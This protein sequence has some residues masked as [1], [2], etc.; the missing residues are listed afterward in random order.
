[1][2]NGFAAFKLTKEYVVAALEKDPIFVARFGQQYYKTCVNT[3]V[4]VDE[5]LTTTSADSWISEHLKC[6]V[7]AIREAID[8]TPYSELWVKYEKALKYQ[9]AKIHDCKKQPT[10]D[11]IKKYVNFSEKNHSIYLVIV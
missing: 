11:E 10:P 8:K 5:L 4:F 2:N 1:M 3:N 7:K 9:L 6:I